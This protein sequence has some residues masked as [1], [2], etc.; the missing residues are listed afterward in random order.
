MWNL[1]KQAKL[2]EAESN[3]MVTR[4]WGW[5]GGTDAVTGTDLQPTGNKPQKSNTQQGI[6]IT[7]SVLIIKL[8][9]RLTPNNCK[10]LE[11]MIIM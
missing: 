8:A 2:V 7:I 10:N 6:Q 5:R 1:N 4:G 11:E 3:T 9:W